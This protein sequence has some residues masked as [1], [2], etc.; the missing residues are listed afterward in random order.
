LSLLSDYHGAKKAGMR[1]LLLR[2]GS[3]DREDKHKESDESVDGSVEVVN[4][5]TEVM[6]WLNARNG[7][8]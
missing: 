1:A 2:R 5:L 6:P 8:L 4:S 3:G 7:G